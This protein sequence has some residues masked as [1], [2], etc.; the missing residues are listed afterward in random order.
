MN[1]KNEIADLLE[2]LLGWLEDEAD[3]TG[4]ESSYAFYRDGLR[5]ALASLQSEP[6][7]LYDIKGCGNHGCQVAPPEGVGTNGACRCCKDPLKMQQVLHNYRILMDPERVEEAA[8]PKPKPKTLSN[9]KAPKPGQGIPKSVAG[10]RLDPEFLAETM[11]RVEESDVEEQDRELRELRRL[12][13]KYPCVNIKRIVQPTGSD[14][15]E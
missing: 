9:A 2:N 3:R 8:K 4:E 15:D 1:N 14:S 12:A 5:K 6:V 10:Q 11:G 13:R 7:T